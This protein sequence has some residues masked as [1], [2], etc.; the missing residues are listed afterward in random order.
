LTRCFKIY[1]GN[2]RLTI[3]QKYRKDFS[4]ESD[5]D[6][7]T[8]VDNTAMICLCYQPYLYFDR[9]IPRFFRF[10]EVAYFSLFPYIVSYIGPLETPL[11][12]AAQNPAVL[13]H[14]MS[15]PIG[16]PIRWFDST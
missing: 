5:A 13:L 14:F 9:I 15:F 2:H 7:A 11:R 6:F 8:L 3:Y 1:E 4:R 10:D 16:L 12:I